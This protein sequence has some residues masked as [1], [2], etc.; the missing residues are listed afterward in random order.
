MDD[1]DQTL[2]RVTDEPRQLMI[3]DILNTDC[4]FR[5]V[6]PDGSSNMEGT[7]GI[8]RRTFKGTIVHRAEAGHYVPKFCS[9][10]SDDQHFACSGYALL[11]NR[12]EGDSAIFL[13]NATTGATRFLTMD[14]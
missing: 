5:T 14:G 8:A 2:R 12:D 6:N 7:S 10:S 4:T 9:W 1:H 11:K 13:L 3:G